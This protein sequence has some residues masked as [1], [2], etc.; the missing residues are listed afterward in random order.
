MYKDVKFPINK[1]KKVLAYLKG[2]QHALISKYLYCFQVEL[3][4]IEKWKK[5]TRIRGRRK[6]ISK[7]TS[8]KRMG[9]TNRDQRK[10]LIL[11]LKTL[12]K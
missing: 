4:S 11:R 3:V 5:G 2:Y 12:R 8:K 10:K 7:R 9:T 6:R 1:S